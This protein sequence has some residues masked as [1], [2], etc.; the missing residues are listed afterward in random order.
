VLRNLRERKA[1]PKAYTVAHLGKPNLTSDPITTDLDGWKPV[2][3][4][5]T[6][7]TWIVSTSSDGAMISGVWEATQGTYHASYAKNEFVHLLEGEIIITPDKGEPME[8]GPGD[9]F[10]VEAGFEGTW[11]IKKP[12]R[13]HFAIQLK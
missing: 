7:K 6:M 11:Q 10:V 5:P 1:M 2:S 13:K 9:A 12:V 4:K 3:G 8:V